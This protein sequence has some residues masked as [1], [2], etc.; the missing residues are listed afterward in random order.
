EEGMQVKTSGEHV[1]KPRRILTALLLAGH[2]TPCDRERSTGDCQLEALGR[3]YGLLDQ[4][5]PF[6]ADLP[7][8]TRAAGEWP[9]GRDDSSRVIAVDHAACILCDRCIRACNDVQ[10]NEVI[11][12]AGRGHG[13]RIAFDLDQPMGQSSCVSCGECV[14]SCPTGAL[15][16][17]PLTLPLVN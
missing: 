5:R 16:N 3:R 15:T 6:P 7:L 1:E 9:R 2:P 8:K 10:C 14:A 17:K 12:R 11:G 4:A 13:A